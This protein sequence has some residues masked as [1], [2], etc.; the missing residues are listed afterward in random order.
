M[1][2]IQVKLV[3]GNKHQT[4][5]VEKNPKI[6][7]GCWISLKPN[8]KILW[9]VTDIHSELDSSLINSDWKVGGLGKR[10]HLNN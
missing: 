5:W 1:L 10:P 2:M 3:R 7:V 6:K 4:C 8:K 9:K